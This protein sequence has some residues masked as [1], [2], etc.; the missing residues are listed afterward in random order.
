MIRL[1]DVVQI[2]H[3]SMPATSAQGF[4]RFHCSDRHDRHAT[5]AGLFGVDDLGMRMLWIAE[6]PRTGI[7]PRATSRNTDSKKSMVESVGIDGSIEILPCAHHPSMRLTDTPGFLGRLKPLAQPL[8]Q[9]GPYVAPNARSWSDPPL[10]RARRGTLRHRAATA[11][12]QNASVRHKESA[13][14]PSA[15][16]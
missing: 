2:L 8:L 7:W 11:S 1:Q 10:Y 9:L 14:A 13:P 6:H 15:A 3:Q 5:E 12:T 4:F 16:T